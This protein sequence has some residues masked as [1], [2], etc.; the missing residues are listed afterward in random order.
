MSDRLLHGMAPK[1]RSLPQGRTTLMSVLDVGSTKV[2]C[3]IARLRPLAES[4]VL[5]HRTHAIQVLGIGH[6]RSRGIK[7]GAVVDLEAAEQAIRQAVDAAERMADVRV[8]SVIV[9]V[10]GGR[11]SGQ[12]LS[13][14]IDLN[15]APARGHHLSRVLE[16]AARHVHQ[17]GRT[18]LHA[19]PQGY[20]VDTARHIEDPEGMVGQKL[21]AS[22]YVIDTDA[23]LVGNL[24]LAVERAHLTIEAMVATPF[25]SGL[26][27]MTADEAELGATVVDMGG[28]S[29]SLGVFAGGHLVHVDAVALGGHH[30][31]MDV[32]RGLSTRLADAERLKTLYG[33]CM[34]CASDDRETVAVRSLSDDDKDMPTHVPKSQLIR[35]IR[36]RVEET[37]ELVRDRLKLSGQLGDAA[38]RFVLTGGAAQLTGLPELAKRILGGPVRL[39]RPLGL[40]GMPEAARGPAFVASAGL[41]IYPQI[42]GVEYFEPSRHGSWFRSSGDSY[43]ARMG[44]WLKESF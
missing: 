16:L 34:A 15:G 23:T 35:I 31:T 42:A 29:T 7:A 2:V 4:E 22:M 13:A 20:H 38:Q 1:M 33:G 44:R 27:V 8:E 18:V 19:L 39:G 43:M 14:D 10:T 26:A 17:P 28:G 9:N 25:A 11:L 12:A 36:P 40:S 21:G 37:L 3:L 24:M 41:L 5:R 6:Q 32:A 30:V